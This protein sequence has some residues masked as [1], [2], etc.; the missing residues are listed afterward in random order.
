MLFDKMKCDIHRWTWQA[1]QDFGVAA[2][3][4]TVN[5]PVWGT[6]YVTGIYGRVVTA[7]AGISLATIEIGFTGDT[8]AIMVKTGLNVTGQHLFMHLSRKTWFCDIATKDSEYDLTA[9]IITFRSADAN[10][11]DLTAGAV[12]II[13]S[14]LVPDN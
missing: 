8:N 7:F 4:L 11:E 6:N 13:V 14:H 3:T 10:L 2:T 12:E 5:F 1:P 9:P